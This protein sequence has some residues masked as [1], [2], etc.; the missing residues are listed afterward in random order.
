MLRILIAGFMLLAS[1]VASSGEVLD[2]LAATVNGHALLQ[3]D[4]QDELRYEFFAAKR[5]MSEASMDDQKAALDRLIDQELLREQ[6]HSKDFQPVPTEEISKALDAFK[7]DYG[8]SPAWTAALAHYKVTEGDIRGHIETELNQLRLID[9]RLRPTVQVDAESVRN[10]Y[11][12]QLLPKL[13]PGQHLSLQEAT[14]T[15][16]ELLI[17]QK[18]DKSLGSWLEVLRSQAKI[19]RFV[20]GDQAK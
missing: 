13:P 3:S 10:Y 6:M 17:Q 16:R 15:I 5:P 2:R 7:S 14:P 18:I 9:L 19:Q 12:Q 20:T 11:Q 4:I 1:T 8:A